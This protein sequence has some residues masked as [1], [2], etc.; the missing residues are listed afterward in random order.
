MSLRRPAAAAPAAFESKIARRAWNPALHPRDSRGRFVET[1][2]IARLWGGGLA[3][4]VR[5][6]SSDMVEVERLDNGIHERMYANRLTMVA[7]PDGSRPTKDRGK[8]EKEDAAREADPQRGDGLDHRDNGHPGVTPKA[9]THGDEDDPEPIPDDKPSVNG[10]LGDWRNGRVHAP[11]ATP[12]SDKT[13]GERAKQVKDV[14]SVIQSAQLTPS[15][16]HVVGK[17]GDQ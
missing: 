17:I 7:R 3:R 6:L 1:G 14:A 10:V 16:R 4:V 13:A 9:P 12:E 5:A 11:A 2:G 15:G 8:G